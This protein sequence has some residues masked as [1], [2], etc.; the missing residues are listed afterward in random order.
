MTSESRNFSNGGRGKENN[1]TTKK[2]SV[3]VS[4]RLQKELRGLMLSPDKGISAFPQMDNI[5]E[6]KG[7]IEGAADTVYEGLK[8][9]L[10]LTFT[11]KYPMD[12]PVVRFITPIFHPNVDDQGNICL[13]ILKEKW[14]ALYEVRTILISIQSLLGEPNVDS[15]LNV[16]AADLWADQKE[17]KQVLQRHY[18]H[19]SKKSSSS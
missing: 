13:D 12:A 19:H 11:S 17:Y 8:F 16:K 7:T 18:E 14:S 2:D 1:L 6:W 10:S 5:F 9:Q 3:S 15:P 4:K